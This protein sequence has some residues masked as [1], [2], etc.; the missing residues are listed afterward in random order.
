MRETILRRGFNSEVHPFPVIPVRAASAGSAVPHATVDIG[1]EYGQPNANEAQNSRLGTRVPTPPWTL[2]WEAKFDASLR[3]YYVLQ[4]GDRVVVRANQ[5]LLYDTR[6]EL[7]RTGGI[8]GGPV[9]MDSFTKRFYRIDP[10]GAMQA[11][12]LPAGDGGYMYFPALGDQFSRVNIG[13][14]GSRVMIAGIERDL[15]PHGGN[16]ATQSSLEIMDAGDSPKTDVAGMIEGH[17]RIGQLYVPGTK[18]AVAVHGERIVAAAPGAV[19]ITNWDLEAV[20]AIEAAFEPVSMSLDETGRIYLV[21]AKEE[22]TSLWVMNA[23]GERSYI[24]DFPPGAAPPR[25]PPIIA[26]DHTVFLAGG[27]VIYAIGTDGKLNWSRTTTGAIAGA[28]VTANNYL[29]VSEGS[30]I[31]A[32][33][34]EGKRQSL[35]K[36]EQELLTAPILTAPGQ[37]LVAGAGRLYCLQ[38]R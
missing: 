8:D 26:Y 36:F 31:A 13:V 29:L 24:W 34:L 7:V 19:Y 37:V 12:D 4:S 10:A 28:V 11:A 27:R 33:N 21:A 18:L 30:E 3:P 6:G 9:V 15:D 1:A 25:T 16:P 14:R 38:S 32:Y 2:A 5:W 17:R 35:F 20:Q 23:A 22:K